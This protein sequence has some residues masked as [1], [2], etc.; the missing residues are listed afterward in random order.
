MAPLMLTIAYAES[1]SHLLLSSDALPA[2]TLRSLLVNK[3]LGQIKLK[4]EPLFCSR[5]TRGL[6]R[7][8]FFQ[9]LTNKRKMY[10][11]SSASLDLRLT[12]I[13]RAAT[14]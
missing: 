7:I 13:L 11:A 6:T 9:N 2:R 10:S 14:P 5:L 1:H 12:L 3:S 4:E 8:S